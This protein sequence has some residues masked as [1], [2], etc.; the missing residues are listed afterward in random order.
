MR[1]A[2]E[3]AIVVGIDGSRSSLEAALWAGAEAARRGLAV[4]L[5]HVYSVPVVRLPIAMPTSDMIREG[6]ES[7]GR[8]WIS[9]AEDAIRR[10]WPDLA[11]E[12]AV[13]EWNPVA[14]LVQESLTAT[15]VVLGSRGLGGFGE[16][17]IGS[18][19][20][21]LAAHGHCPVVLARG[22]AL[23]A[24]G[25]VVV[26][27]DGA[28]ASEAAMGFAFEEAA[29]RGVGLT[30]VHT[31]TELVDDDPAGPIAAWRNKYPDL[32]VEY[33]VRPGRPATALLAA[34]EHAQLVVV[35]SRGLGG[36]KGMLLGSTSQA[37]LTH[38]T[39]A[40]A[41]VRPAIAGETLPDKE[42]DR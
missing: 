36:F 29:L 7:Q 5:V 6:F 8:A 27:V 16:L 1:F 18:T 34:A 10:Q 38:A 13:R 23:S 4:R 26:G 19:A 32:P 11:V 37:L 3:G 15:M 40:V 9:E 21:A 20:V 28:P 14:A 30:A 33:I 39:C 41:V 24:E 2:T 22:Q 42:I 25:P 31:W 35:G 12:T 17:L